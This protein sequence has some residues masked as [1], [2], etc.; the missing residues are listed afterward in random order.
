M[1]QKLLAIV[2]GLV[3]AGWMITRDQKAKDETSEAVLADSQ[4]LMQQMEGYEDDKEYIESVVARAHEPAF[5]TAYKSGRRGRRFRPSE[6]ASFNDDKYLSVLFLNMG[7]TIQKDIN[8][9]GARDRKKYE[10]V[11]QHLDDLKKKLQIENVRDL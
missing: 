2:V 6:P 7:S 5:S 8:D 9:A 4:L 1:G 10:G 3:V 11:R